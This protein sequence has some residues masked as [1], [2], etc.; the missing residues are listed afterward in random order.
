[1]LSQVH[2]H[3][4]VQWEGGASVVR[5]HDTVLIQV[6]PDRVWAWLTDLPRHYREWHPAHLDCRYVR[7]N[8]L[9]T[10]AA[11]QVV[12]Q[13]HGKPHSLKL[14]A[15][16]VVPN[17]LLRYTGRGF[18]GAFILEPAERGTCFTAE[19]ELG[20]H[21]PVVGRLLDTVLRRLLAKRLTAFQV[22]MR[23][24]GQKLKELLET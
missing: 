21:L 6:P 16:V 18:Q 14:H 12:E 13:L 15:T 20:I 7:G 2:V 17:R 9:T 22:H 3:G 1:M 24:E 11:L 23:E 5:L 10:G 4:A 19:L 8:S